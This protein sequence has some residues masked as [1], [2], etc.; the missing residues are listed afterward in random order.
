MLRQA[1][2]SVRLVKFVTIQGLLVPW[3]H[4][5]RMCWSE[6]KLRSATNL[7]GVVRLQRSQ[8]SSMMG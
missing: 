1:M 5:T 2:K 3:R 7:A 6:V 4:L 8:T